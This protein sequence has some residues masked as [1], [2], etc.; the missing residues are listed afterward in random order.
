MKVRI[1][2]AILAAAVVSLAG[3][4]DQTP[5]EKKMERVKEKA[6]Q[7][8]RQFERGRLPKIKAVPTIPSLAPADVYQDLED[9]GYQCFRLETGRLKVHWYCHGAGPLGEGMVDV[10]GPDAGS[11]RLVQATYLDYSGADI[12][13]VGGKFLGYVAAI[14]YEG[15][16]AKEARLWVKANIG[17]DVDDEFG[18]VSYALFANGPTRSLE[19]GE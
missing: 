4:S 18:G 7:A 6:E 3:C 1:A 9:R 17:Q 8:E 11:V 14:P 15:A 19:I 5:A 13:V 2:L 12:D 16:T 10:Y